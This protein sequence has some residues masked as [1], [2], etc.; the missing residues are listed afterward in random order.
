ME[1]IW[2]PSLLVFERLCGLAQSFDGGLGSRI[3]GPC[4][5]W[6]Y[7]C[8]FARLWTCRLDYFAYSKPFYARWG[9][10]MLRI[11]VKIGSASWRWF[12]C[13]LYCLW[14]VQVCQQ[15]F[16][17]NLETII[18]DGVL[19]RL[20]LHIEENVTNLS[21]YIVAGSYMENHDGSLLCLLYCG[22]KAWPVP[23]WGHIK[24]QISTQAHRWPQVRW[25]PSTTPSGL[26]QFLWIF[27][28]LVSIRLYCCGLVV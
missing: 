15:P 16:F 20:T 25:Y 3:T 21:R 19:V 11:L 24:K 13:P 23:L 28:R 5:L 18:A 1:F 12:R 7:C 9:L 4:W 2:S 22:S 17:V 8:S 27:M 10:I 26:P 6:F 14:K